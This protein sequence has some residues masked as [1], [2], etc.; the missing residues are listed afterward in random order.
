MPKLYDVHTHVGIDTGFYLRGWWP[1]GATAQDL[2]ER[3]REN[4]I[5][6]AVCF[7]FTLP[8]AFD[9]Y[10]FERGELSLLDGRFPFDRENALL[11]NEIARA[12][13]QKQLIQFA[14][15]DPSRRV[16]EQVKKIQP[17]IGRIGG[18]KTQTTILKSPIRDLLG[19]GR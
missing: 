5:D 9:P 14:M 18:L 11:A 12:D 6:R 16:A 3:M 1:Y 19:N 7:P 10:A 15:F 17:L 2:L 13:S 8:S 4:K